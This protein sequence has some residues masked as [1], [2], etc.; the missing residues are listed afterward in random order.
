M[1]PQGSDKDK[2]SPFILSSLSKGRNDILR[3]ALRNFSLRRTNPHISNPFPLLAIIMNC[4]DSTQKCS[5]NIPNYTKSSYH[6]KA[7]YQE[8]VFSNMSKLKICCNHHIMCNTI[9][10]ADLEDHK[11]RSTEDNSST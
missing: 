1:Q 7:K 3:L 2:W 4:S 8:K 11:G 10:D 9:A 5:K 6:P